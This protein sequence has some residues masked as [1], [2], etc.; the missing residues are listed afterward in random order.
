MNGIP[1]AGLNKQL[2]AHERPNGK[3]TFNTRRPRNNDSTLAGCLMDI[4]EELNPDSERYKKDA[5]LHPV[6]FAPR[7]VRALLLV[8]LKNTI[9][10]FVRF[11]V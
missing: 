3:K 7:I 9:V 11:M 8:G 5:Q 10:I 1:Y 4:E 6:S 2:P